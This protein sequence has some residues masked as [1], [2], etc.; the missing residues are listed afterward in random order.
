MERQ[1]RFLEKQEQPLLLLLLLVQQHPVMPQAADDEDD[2]WHFRRRR[3]RQWRPFCCDVVECVLDK[4]FVVDSG[5][6]IVM[7]D[8]NRGSDSCMVQIDIISSS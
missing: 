5:C 4:S 2:E 1:L 6:C 7:S 8:D 3:R